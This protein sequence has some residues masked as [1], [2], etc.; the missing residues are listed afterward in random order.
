[1]A[2]LG[3]RDLVA[4]RRLLDRGGHEVGGQGQIGRLSLEALRFRLGP[5]ALDLAPDAAEDVGRVGDAQLGGVQ[6]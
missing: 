2:L 5:G 3:G 6:A 4:Q 1:M